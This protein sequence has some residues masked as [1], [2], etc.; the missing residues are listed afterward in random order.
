LCQWKAEHPRFDALNITDNP[1][2]H[3]MLSGDPALEAHPA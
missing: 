2:V 3:A 1:G